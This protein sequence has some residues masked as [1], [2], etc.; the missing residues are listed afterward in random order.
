MRVSRVAFR[1]HLLVVCCTLLGCDA[2]GRGPE[3]ASIHGIVTVDGVPVEEGMLQFRP[4]Q[5]NTGPVT[6]AVV[7]DGEYSTPK[8]KG[9]VLG[10]HQVAIR[11]SRKTGKMIE[12][13]FGPAE[14]REPV[15]PKEYAEESTL[16]RDVKAG[17]N[18]FN[19]E[20]SSTPEG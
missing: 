5:G 9:P 12:T 8:K 18:E 17:D 10:L 6:G 11:G 15:V 20:L 19:F 14:E 7:T 16:V 1:Y 2:A 13:R 3:R 4:T